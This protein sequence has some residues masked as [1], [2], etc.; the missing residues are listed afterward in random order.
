MHEHI[1]QAVFVY[2]DTCVTQY[3]GLNVQG[4][5]RGD[6]GNSRRSVV[7]TVLLG[8]KVHSPSTTR[9]VRIY[10]TFRHRP[11]GS[12]NDLETELAL[13]FDKGVFG[14]VGPSVGYRRN[15]RPCGMAAA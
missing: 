13:F 6:T 4:H 8:Y 9:D 10:K 15:V 14:R 2:C 5:L 7:K 11:P 1:D 12:K 3:F